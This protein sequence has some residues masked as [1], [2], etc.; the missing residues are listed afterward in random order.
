MTH[1][2]YCGTRVISINDIAVFRNTAISTALKKLVVEKHRCE[3]PR[4]SLDQTEV[5]KCV[6]MKL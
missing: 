5:V 2:A 3:R 1:T 4:Q 6:V